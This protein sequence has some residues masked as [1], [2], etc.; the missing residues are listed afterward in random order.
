MSEVDNSNES[1]SAEKEQGRFIIA[2]EM[3]D[4]VATPEVDD[5]LEDKSQHDTEE[6]GVESVSPLFAYLALMNYLTFA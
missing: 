4:C 6:S 3:V 1:V 5:L 2:G